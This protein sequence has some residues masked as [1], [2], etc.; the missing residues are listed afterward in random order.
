[1]LRTLLLFLLLV[2]A[3]PARALDVCQPPRVVPGQRVVFEASGAPPGARVAF[4]RG[5]GPGQTCPVGLGGACFNL[6]HAVL[7]ATIPADAQGNARFDRVLPANLP[8]GFRFGVQVA[9][10]VGGRFLLSHPFFAATQLPGDPSTACATG[11]VCATQDADLDGVNDLCD[12]C[13]DD[14]ATCPSVVPNPN[15][16]CSARGWVGV[17]ATG[18]C[19]DLVPSNETALWDVRP[20]ML[21]SNATPAEI[22]WFN[23][24]PPE[25]RGLCS[26]SPALGA[27]QPAGRADPDCEIMNTFSTPADVSNALLDPLRD[28]FLTNSGGPVG[29]V[30]EP[31][32]PWVAVIDTAVTRAPGIAVDPPDQ[33]RH[34]CSMTALVH[35]LTCD[36][37]GSC[38]V[39]VGTWLALDRDPNAPGGVNTVAGGYLGT[40]ATLATRILDAVRDW[41]LA[42]RPGPLVIHLAVGWE[43]EYTWRAGS[44]GTESVGARTVRL[45]L[46]YAACQ[47]ALIVAAAGNERGG[48]VPSP[49][50]MYPAA[51]AANP[52]PDCAATGTSREAGLLYAVDAVGEDGSLILRSRDMAL[53]RLVAWGWQAMADIQRWAPSCGLQGAPVTA[54]T[55]TSVATAVL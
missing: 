44:P 6:S 17:S 54:L 37:R 15:R 40:Q 29:A 52:A 51:W 25:L 27:S 10:R 50:P 43:P 14:S 24:L 11:R 19:A 38:G 32:A 16:T 47:G 42:G 7:L 28:A 48:P 26:L 49:G 46:E 5:D 45:A 33:A 36:A 20:T 12:L 13:A 2:V 23:R 9:V 31:D 55:G 4:I 3:A 35:D 34:G 21:R 1:M 22:G 41:D 8:A 18:N 39:K 53:P 30:L